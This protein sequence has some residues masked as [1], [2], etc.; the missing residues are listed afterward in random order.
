MYYFY[1][2]S[3]LRLQESDLCNYN[4]LYLSFKA[5]LWDNSYANKNVI[6]NQRFYRKI[7]NRLI[8]LTKIDTGIFVW[9]HNS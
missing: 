7:E 3:D 9:Y 6:Q 5:I 4:A 2:I 1:G 8:I